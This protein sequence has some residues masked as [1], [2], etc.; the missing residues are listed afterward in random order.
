L[1]CGIQWN[2][3]DKD[4]KNDLV[5]PWVVKKKLLSL[6]FVLMKQKTFF[7]K[8]K[9][10]KSFPIAAFPTENLHEYGAL[11]WG[12]GGLGSRWLFEQ[13]TE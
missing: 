9:P 12:A 13:V 2:A 11:R 7:Q 3:A 8:Y 10:W 5:F 4:I 1:C 6:S